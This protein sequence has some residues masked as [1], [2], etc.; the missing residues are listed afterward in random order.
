MLGMSYP[1]WLTVMAML[2]PHPALKAVSPQ[3]SPADMFLGDDFHHNGAF[4]LSYGFEYAAMMET[5]KENH[6]PSSSIS[7][8]TY[9]WYLRLGSLSTST[10]SICT[11]SIPTWN[12]FVEHPELRRVLAAAGVAPYLD[13]VTVPTLNVAG[14]WDQEDFYGPVKIYERSRRTTPKHLNYLVVGP[15][16]HGGWSAAAGASS[17]RSTSAA[18]PRVLPHE[19]PSAVVRVLAEG[20]GHAEACRR[21]PTFEAGVEHVAARA[22]AGRRTG[23]TDRDSTSGRPASCRSTPPTSTPSSASDAYVSDPAQS[24][25]VPRAPDS[26]DV[27][28][29]LDVVDAGSWTISD[30]VDDRAGRA[31]LGDA[32]RSTERRVD[33]GRHRGAP[34][35]LD[36]RQRCRLGREAH[37]RLSRQRSGGHDRS[38]AIS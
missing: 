33:R 24:G 30:F 6:A 29:G 11:A 27:R 22:T 37:R 31:Q 13:S 8:D 26:A 23:V 17:A 4:R 10:R 16:N 5:A 12:D 32:R 36:H 38:R 35:R 21:R 18:T 34:V 14:W 19:D 2:D 9:D 15:W 7:Y 1:G 20:Q 3:A 25:A 28:R